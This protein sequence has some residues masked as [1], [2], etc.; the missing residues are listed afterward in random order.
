MVCRPNVAHV[1][2]FGGPSDFTKEIINMA[3]RGKGDCDMK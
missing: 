3:Q 1:N 2:S